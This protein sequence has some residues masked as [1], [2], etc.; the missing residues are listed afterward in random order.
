M[1]PDGNQELPTEKVYKS[2]FQSVS[3]VYIQGDC[4]AIFSRLTLYLF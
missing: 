1:L 2:R 4:I 3:I